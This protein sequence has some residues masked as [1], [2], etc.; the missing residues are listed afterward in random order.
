MKIRE[1][2][3]IVRRRLLVVVAL[4]ALGVAAGWVTAP[5]T[6][7]RTT[8]FSATH[9]LFYD[10]QGSGQNYNIEQ[11]ALLA[12]SGPVPSRVAAAL[13]VGRAQVRSAVSAVADAKVATISISGRAPEAAR[14]E[15]LANTTAAELVVELS[16]GDQAGYQAEIDRLTADVDEARRRLAATR[17]PAQQAPVRAE[18]QAAERALADFRLSGPPA[19]A[20][21]TLEPAVAGSVASQGMQAPNS[22]PVRALLLGVLGLLAGLGAAVA[23]DRSDSRIRTKGGAENAFGAPVIA[24]VPPLPRNSNGQL[25]I[26][27]QSSSAFVEAYRGLRTH[28]ALWAMEDRQDDGHRV[29]VV[30]SAGASEGK[31]T[32]VAHIAA[33][34]AEI[35]RSVIVVSA[36]LR[37][38][39]LHHYFDRPSGPGIVDVLSGAPGAPSFE[40]LDLS[41][42]VR[43]VRLLRSG[44]AVENP[45]P[46]FEQAGELIRK[47]RTMADFVLVDAPPLLVAND[48]VD[49]ARHADGVLFVA[50]AGKTT[51]EG[52]QR[53]A[54]M[55]G[56]LEIPVVGAVLV[57]SEAAANAY[58]HY[59]AH[60]YA[61]PQAE[62]GRRR[63]RADDND[64]SPPPTDQSPPPG[65]DPEP[66]PAEAPTVGVPVRFGL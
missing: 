42:S 40:A 32:S 64:Q 18:L 16:G 1:S 60:Y 59:G 19:P 28:V 30:T 17:K 7:A 36:D 5:G 47:A 27:T 62:G 13:Q 49:L 38:P 63:R 35:G 12:T 66:E 57:A 29:I 43:G 22:K 33:L 8:S 61:E 15:A 50:H 10:P 37:R 25:L 2:L 65:A 55:L 39:Q 3:Q 41:T 46:L 54:E 24:E 4:L 45:A 11:V 58:R 6:T 44:P 56:R 26:R 34:L 31:T 21:K 14:A 48:A 53:S 51:V 9:T 20:L 52:A 23:L